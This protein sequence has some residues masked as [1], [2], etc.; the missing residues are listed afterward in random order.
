MTHDDV[1]R[2]FLEFFIERGH[3]RIPGSTLFP[4]DPDDP[5]L[6]VSSGMHP[7]TPFLSGRPHPQGRRL[8][9]CQRCLRTTDLDEVGD[10]TH[11]SLFE[12]LG[13][14]SLGDYDGP[15]SLRWGLE[16]LTDGFGIPRERLSVTVFGGSP[17][18]GPDTRSLDTWQQLGMRDRVTLTGSE[19]W[20]SNGP[21]GLCGPDSEIFVWTG[22]GEPQGDPTS[23]ERWVEVWNHVMMRYRR[24]P[25]G[26]LEGLE[27]R[28]VDT[29]MGFER[30]VSVVQGV[31]SIYDTDLLSPWTDVVGSVWGLSGRPLRIVVDGLRSSLVLLGDGVRPGN[32]GRPYVLRRLLRR[33][34]RELDGD[35]SDLPSRLVQETVEHFELRCDENW[36][37]DELSREQGRY[38]KNVERGRREV[39]KLL[40]CGPVGPLERRWLW[41]THGVSPELVDEVLGTD[42]GDSR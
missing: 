41:E 27:Q 10:D 21:V 12:M 14:W 13:S 17:D 35:V 32:S 5:V 37:L 25:D 40:R 24:L 28:N 38:R 3:R 31:R 36:L 22:D 18:C 30:I 26:R 8:V 20:W 29:G 16:L 33:S 6:L 1:R 34:L 11:V 15:R 7:L 2:T 39:G 23:D 4:P 19:N 9:N 42:A